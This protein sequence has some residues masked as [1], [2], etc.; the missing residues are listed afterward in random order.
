MQSDK[1]TTVHV[2]GSKSLTQRALVAAALAEGNSFVR[3]ALVAEDTLYLMDGL[4]SLG[5][6]IDSAGD[7]YFVSGVGGKIIN[8]GKEIFL[9]NNGTALRFLTVLTTLGKGKYILNGEKRLRERP[10]GALVAALQS[11]GVDISCNNNCPPVTVN[12]A[13]LQGGKIILKDIESSQYVSAL[14]L[15]APYT[16][17]GIDLDFGRA[18]LYR[19]LILI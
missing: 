17:Q 3:N 12:A 11:M 6:H 15:C 18:R 2:P 16:K 10:V 1:N 4:R 13:G 19:L 9:G 7:G 14:L 8:E 5:A